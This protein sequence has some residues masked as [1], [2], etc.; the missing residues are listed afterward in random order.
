MIAV[1]GENGQV[2]LKWKRIE[3]ISVEMLLFKVPS[4]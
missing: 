1:Y 2:N 3:L 4:F